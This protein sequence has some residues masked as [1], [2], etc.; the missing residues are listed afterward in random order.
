MSTASI[1]FTKAHLRHARSAVISAK[2]AVSVIPAK[3][4]IHFALAATSSS[5]EQKWIPAFAGMTSVWD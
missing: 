3:A 1:E 2:A 4:G 5:G